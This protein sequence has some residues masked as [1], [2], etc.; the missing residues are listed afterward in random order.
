[1]VAMPVDEGA[2]VDQ[3]RHIRRPATTGF[4]LGDRQ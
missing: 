3:H 1:V 4:A 2:F